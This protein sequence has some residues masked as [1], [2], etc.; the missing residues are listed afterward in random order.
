LA[1]NHGNRV[2]CDAMLRMYYRVN[3]QAAQERQAVQEK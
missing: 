3:K 1:N 2:M